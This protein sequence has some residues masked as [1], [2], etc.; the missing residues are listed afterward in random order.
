MRTLSMLLVCF[1]PLACVLA[2]GCV[3]T[4]ALNTA[5]IATNLTARSLEAADASFA[6]VLAEAIHHADAAHPDDDAAYGAELAPLTN[7]YE[8]LEEARRAEQL[9]HLAVELWKQ[10]DDG[11]MWREEL[12]CAVVALAAVE[13]LVQSDTARAALTSAI[14]SLAALAGTATCKPGVR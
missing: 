7:V 10:G 9:M 12:P 14:Q 2:Q 6:P 8:K 4:S 11:D 1:L 3:S 5:T 13:P